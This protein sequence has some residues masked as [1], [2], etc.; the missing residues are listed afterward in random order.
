MDD[1]TASRTK[2]VFGDH[3]GLRQQGNAKK[4]IERNYVED[5]VVLANRGAF[6]GH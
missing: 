1:P 4:G 6:R 2:E 5:C 3:L